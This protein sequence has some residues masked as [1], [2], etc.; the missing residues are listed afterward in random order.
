VKEVEKYLLLA[1]LYSDQIQNS[2]SF[3]EITETALEEESP[4]SQTRYISGER[5][6]P[7]TCSHC[8]KADHNSNKC[9]S[10]GGKRR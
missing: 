9:Y 7:R 2:E 4:I 10:K 1:G 8:G 6:T 3:D 5:A